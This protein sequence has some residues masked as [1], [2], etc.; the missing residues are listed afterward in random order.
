MNQYIYV[1][2]DGKDAIVV[3]CKIVAY[4]RDKYVTVD[5]GGKLEDIKSYWVRHV[6]GKHVKIRHLLKY[7]RPTYDGT[8]P[9]PFTRKELAKSRKGAKPK[10]TYEVWVR[11]EDAPNTR[12]SF[13]QVNEAVDYVIGRNLTDYVIHKLVSTDYYNNWDEAVEREG[14]S[15]HFN[16]NEYLSSKRQRYILENSK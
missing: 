10:V 8:T 11:N 12:L 1:D 9:V 6:N 15:V 16:V 2:R 7:P 3:P 14:G 5:V 4:D 13:K